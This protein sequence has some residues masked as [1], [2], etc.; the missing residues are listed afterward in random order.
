VPQTL[1]EATGPEP[2]ALV[3]MREPG[4]DRFRFDIVLQGSGGNGILRL[5]AAR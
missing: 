2:D 5:L 3:A 1:T 4:V